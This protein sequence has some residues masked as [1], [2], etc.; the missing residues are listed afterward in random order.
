[1]TPLYYAVEGIDIW[2]AW[3]DSGA[4][5]E[6]RDAD[7]YAAAKPVGQAFRA[8][9]VQFA[10]TATLGGAWRPFPAVCEYGADRE[11]CSE[12]NAH[13]RACAILD[14]AA[15]RRWDLELGR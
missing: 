8:S 7:G 5:K 2:L 4:P 11:T 15:G 14:K 6:L 12:E 1:M 9:L 13:A 3:G 10:R